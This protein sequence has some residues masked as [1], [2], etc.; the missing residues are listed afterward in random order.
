MKISTLLRG[1]RG[2]T[3]RFIPRSRVRGVV[4]GLVGAV[5]FGSGAPLSRLV[6][7]VDRLVLSVLVYVGAAIGLSLITLARPRRWNT[8]P[9]LSRADLPLI[10]V[11]VVTTSL[12]QLFQILGTARVSG[13]VGALALSLQLPLTA[14]IAVAFFRDRFNLAEVIGIL[15]VCAGVGLLGL[16]PGSGISDVMG[17]SFIAV[18]SLAW[19]L[20][21]NLTQ[22][23]SG[24]DPLALAR[25][26]AIVAA[27]ISLPIL[28]LIGAEVPGD[29]AVL[30][31][32]LGLG[33]VC[34]GIPEILII[35]SI[36]HLG[37]TRAEAVSAT[38]PFAGAI[39]AFAAL[40]VRPSSTTFVTAGVIAAGLWCLLWGTSRAAAE[41][42]RPIDPHPDP[43]PS[44]TDAQP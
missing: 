10:S 28:A 11:L 14:V 33:L 35:S 18:S 7:D 39:I 2:P 5:L 8:M 41:R 13:D 42:R 20:D 25:L 9:Q 12:A 24:R 30:A 16:Q 21:S 43:V 27:A 17:M 38:A 31:R 1:R 4:Y 26:K 34:F 32:A 6:G 19:A 36:R 29:P 44:L 3:T 23:L 40:G 22:R 15:V 37:A